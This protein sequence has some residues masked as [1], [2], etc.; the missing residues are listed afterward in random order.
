MKSKQLLNQVTFYTDL[1]TSGCFL[2]ASTRKETGEVVRSVRL[3]IPC[4]LTDFG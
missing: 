4:F 1:T 2:P 3:N